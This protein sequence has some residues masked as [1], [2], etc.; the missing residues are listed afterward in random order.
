MSI[1][2]LIGIWWHL[3]PYRLST[4]REVVALGP[5][6][7]PPEAG[8]A[9]ARVGALPLPVHPTELVAGLGEGPPDPFHHAPGGPA[10]EP[11]VDGALGPE[12]RGELVPLAAGPHAEDDPVEHLAPVGDASAGRLL[13]PE[14]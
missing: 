8:L 11:V 9:Q 3:P 12:L 13:G 4:D 14:V 2:L 7:F 10:L 6:F 5:V 1:S